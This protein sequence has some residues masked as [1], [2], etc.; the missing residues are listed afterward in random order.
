MKGKQKFYLCSVCGNLVGMIENG[1]VPLNCCGMDMDELAANTVDAS[2]EKH[3][4]EVT[5]DGS[6]V[7]V[8]IGSILHPMETAHHVQFIYLETKHGGQR[9]SLQA[10]EEPKASFCLLDDSPIAV[11]EYCNLHGL[12]KT[13]LV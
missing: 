6:Q 10:G 3:L 9:K 5:V 7:H 12:W 4:P 2:T 8:A 13:E 1:G 11:Y